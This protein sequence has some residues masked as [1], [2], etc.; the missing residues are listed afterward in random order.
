MK[1]T[2]III[3]ALIL[4]SCDCKKKCPLKKSENSCMK[5]LGLYVENGVL[6]KNDKP[7]Q[8]I[9]VNYFDLFYR[10][11]KNTNDNSYVKGIEQLSEAEIP[12][13]RFMCGGFWPTENKLYI[14]DKEA[15]FKLLDEIVETA[16][17]NNV[18]LIPSLFFFHPCAADTMK[19]PLDQ[20][21]NRKKQ[22][23]CF[24]QKIY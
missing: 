14:D 8:S 2:I 9:G 3:T 15:Y 12:F 4:T 18:G 10:V 19:E 7:Y 17:K 21:G 23:H 22:N 16:E 24:Y 6:K 5:K 1:T 13:A 11:L 20:L